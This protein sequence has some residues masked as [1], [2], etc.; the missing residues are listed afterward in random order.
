M[1]WLKRT[2]LG[3]QITK[4]RVIARNRHDLGASTSSLSWLTAY[5]EK[6]VDHDGFIKD[7]YHDYVTSIS[8]DDKA[9]S[10]ELA[11]LLWFILNTTSP[12]LVVDLGS[13]FSSFL[14]RH[15]QLQCA[16]AG[17]ACRV[18]SCDDDEQWLDRTANFL[19]NRKLS[20]E[21]LLSWQRFLEEH[22]HARPDLI[23]HDLGYMP[24]RIRTL[25]QALDLCE[26]QAIAII[27]DVHKPLMR[28][29]TLNQ[30]RRRGLRG[31]DL[32]RF[33]FD[34]FGRYSW[35]VHNSEFVND[36]KPQ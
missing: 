1:T 2:K 12:K 24:V 34:R 10:L 31:Y 22:G 15:Y 25:P 16:K 18:F 5:E 32:T 20:T 3:Q 7:A 9:I 23:L 8:T 35:L 4:S 21:G 19:Q 11:Y 27:D 28:Q 30:I 33:T 13:G 6:K 26:T 17:D 29:E 36:F 14:F